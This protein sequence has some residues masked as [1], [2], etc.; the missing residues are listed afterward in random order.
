MTPTKHMQLLNAQ[1]PSWLA[2]SEAHRF[3]QQIL[4]F[5]QVW[6]FKQQHGSCVF[7]CRGWWLVCRMLGRCDPDGMHQQQGT[8]DSW[9]QP[10][11]SESNRISGLGAPNVDVLP[12]ARRT[13]PPLLRW[14]WQH[15]AQRRT[16]CGGCRC[17]GHSA[18]LSAQWARTSWLSC[19]QPG[20][21]AAGVHLL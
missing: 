1:R 3:L 2:N 15:V 21:G 9:Q 20:D 5:L 18:C 12:L 11:K 10:A 4:L 13:H 8:C 7:V 16:R 14:P 17:Q 19:A 6:P